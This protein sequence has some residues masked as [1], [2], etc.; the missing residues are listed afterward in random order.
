[1][2]IGKIDITKQLD[3]FENGAG[4]FG[5]EVDLY[6]SK[7][8]RKVDKPGDITKNEMIQ[9]ILYLDGQN[10]AASLSNSKSILKNDRAVNVNLR[11]MMED[12]KADDLKDLYYLALAKWMI[13]SKADLRAE[14]KEI[15]DKAAKKQLIIAL[16][17]LGIR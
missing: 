13:A 5:R 7:G 14:L 17:N 15:D 10:L 16:N 2:P 3:K 4:L 6:E 1:M 11:K 8:W 9:A 12:N